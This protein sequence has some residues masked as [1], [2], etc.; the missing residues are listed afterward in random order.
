MPRKRTQNENDNIKQELVRFNVRIFCVEITRKSYQHKVYFIDEI[1]E[2][3]QNVH[4][5]VQ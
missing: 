3:L 4:L 2:K 1:D 5:S